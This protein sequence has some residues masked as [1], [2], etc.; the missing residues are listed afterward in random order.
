[1]YIDGKEF[2]SVADMENQTELLLKI[3]ILAEDKQ[4]LLKE[5]EYA[6]ISEATLFPEMEYQS[7]DIKKQYSTPALNQ[8]LNTWKLKRSPLYFLCLLQLQFL[9]IGVNKPKER[10][11]LRPLVNPFYMRLTAEI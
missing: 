9:H 7:K 4:I 5:L 11:V 1:M 8:I 6:G 2:I 10:F 3:R